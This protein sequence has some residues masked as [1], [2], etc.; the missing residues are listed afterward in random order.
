[1]W[2]GVERDL[3]SRAACWSS[4]FLFFSCI[5]QIN[6]WTSCAKNEERFSTSLPVL[7]RSKHRG[8]QVLTARPAKEDSLHRTPRL[9]G[10]LQPKRRTSCFWLSMPCRRQVHWCNWAHHVSECSEGHDAGENPGI[11]NPTALAHAKSRY[12]MP[13]LTSRS[14]IFASATLACSRKAET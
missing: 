3:T 8:A 5:C 4:K 2:L 13:G 12:A 11:S 7:R 6:K 14:G 9:G 1:M 10:P